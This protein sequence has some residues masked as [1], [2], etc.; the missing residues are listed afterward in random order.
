MHFYTGIALSNITKTDI[1]VAAAT[2][3]KSTAPRFHTSDMSLPF[4]KQNLCAL[5]LVRNTDVVTSVNCACHRSVERLLI[6][7]RIYEKERPDITLL[8]RS[9][10]TKYSFILPTEKKSAKH[11]LINAAQ[12]AITSWERGER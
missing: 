9:P 8:V 4:M 1:L 2:W 11:W 7:N 12:S 5:V 3:Y 10:L 6:N